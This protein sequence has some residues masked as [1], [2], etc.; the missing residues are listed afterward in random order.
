[1]LIGAIGLTTVAIHAS[2]SF[3]IPGSS[4]LAGVGASNASAHCP[5]DMAYVPASGGGFCIDRYED[6][7]GDVCPHVEPGNQ[8]DTDA[9]LH[10]PLCFA[11]LEK[12]IETLG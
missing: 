12:R 4:L 11:C 1:M 7:A 3:S 2:D 10:D 5:P 8:F 6:A 9:N